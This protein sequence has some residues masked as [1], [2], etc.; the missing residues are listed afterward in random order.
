MKS[1][2]SKSMML[3]MAVIIVNFG[4]KI[5]LSY[6][7]SK[8]DIGL[9]YTSIDM[10]AVVSLFFT[11]YKDSMIKVFAE[12]N[13]LAIKNYIF[14]QYLIMSLLFL[15]ILYLMFENYQDVN[16][17]YPVTLFLLFF[18]VSQVSNYY[19]YLNVAHR[20]YNSMLYEKSIKAISLILSFVILIKF[21][22]LITSLIL[23]YIVQLTMHILYIKITSPHIYFI[24]VKNNDKQVYKKFLKNFKISTVT[25]F[26]GSITIYLSAIILFY[27]YAD[28]DIL[29][30]Y[31][32]VVKS[33]FFALVAVFVHPITAYTFPELSK[34]IAQKSYSEVKQL[35]IKIQKYLGLFFIFTFILTLFTKRGIGL[36]FP[37]DYAQSYKML[38][39]LLPILPFIAYT[40]FAINIIK[41]FDHFDLALYVRILGSVVFF[42]STYL[43]YLFD[44]D[45]TSIVYSLDLSFFAM[46]LHAY[47]YKQRLLK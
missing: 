33:I 6:H 41:G 39:I 5:Y 7:I 31:Q 12:N 44:F 36:M 4:F 17:L 15:P 46:F 23:A 47:Y 26:F 22:S 37:S 40:S 21:Y 43:F 25:S 10:V 45:A 24:D 9:F 11:G 16:I 38:N 19:S 20:N 8:E 18:T 1:I 2:I 28:S 30:Q 42:G 34:L 14:R 35:D 32:V 29:A 3:T 27:L 13:F